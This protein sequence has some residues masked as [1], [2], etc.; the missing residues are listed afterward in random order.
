MVRPL[1]DYSSTVWDPH[2]R[3]HR[4][5]IESVQR[6]STRWIKSDYQR[7]SSVTAML[8][9]LGLSTLEERRKHQRMTLMYKIVHGYVQIT[10]EHLDLEDAYSRTRAS[11]SHKFCQI[12]CKTTEYLHSFSPKSVPEWNSLPASMAEASSLDIFKAQL[13]APPA[14]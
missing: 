10:R 12:Q 14:V 1:L 11:H 4:D 8:A 13:A 7:E 3:Q 5:K 6:K 2:Q 9:E